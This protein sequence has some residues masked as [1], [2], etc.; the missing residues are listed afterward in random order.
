MPTADE[1]LSHCLAKPGAWQDSPWDDHVVAKVG[2]AGKIF[3]SIGD[4]SIG[5]KAGTRD[6]ADEWLHEFP[7]DASVMAYIG[8]HGW[9]SLR[10][11]A[12]IPD[13]A[14]LAAIDESYL[15]VVEKLPKSKRP[16]GW[17]GT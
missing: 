2:E 8:K 3:C 12:G 5:V 17:D 1:I 7:D 16:E 6:E 14:L 15:Y 11:G 9:N 13:T 10:V 4:G